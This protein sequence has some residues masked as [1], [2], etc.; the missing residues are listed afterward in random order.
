MFLIKDEHVALG[1]VYQCIKTLSVL[2]CS[3]GEYVMRY[4]RADSMELFSFGMDILPFAISESC[5]VS[6]GEGFKN[7]TLEIISTSEP[8]DI[9][10]KKSS[11][12]CSKEGF[13]SEILEKKSSKEG[14]KGEVLEILTHGCKDFKE[15][16]FITFQVHHH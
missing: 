1:V 4:M 11:F 9:L 8:I 16:E 14:F 15:S 12:T 3:V 10:E 6:E 13:K 7:E 5:K 2:G